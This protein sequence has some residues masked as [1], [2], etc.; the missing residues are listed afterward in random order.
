[1]SFVKDF[2]VTTGLMAVGL[3]L[4]GRDAERQASQAVKIYAEAL[5]ISEEEA[6]D[7]LEA[8]AARMATEKAQRQAETR[9]AWKRRLDRVKAWALG[10]EREAQG[11]HR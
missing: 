6:A 11:T 1:M 10:G 5:G 4:I 9:A 3:A 7:R 2:L 8:T